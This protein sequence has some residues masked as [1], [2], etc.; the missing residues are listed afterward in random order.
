MK[1]NKAK[2]MFSTISPVYETSI[3]MKSIYKA[4]GSETELS[5]ELAADILKQLFPQTATWGLILWEERL[6]LI[7]NLNEN[8]Q[9]RRAKVISKLQSRNKIINP[10]QMALIISNY[11]KA[12]VNIVEDVAPYMF[13]INLLSY[14]GFPTELKDMYKEVKRIKPSHLGVNY[15]LTAITQ[16][17]FFIGLTSFTGEAITTYP[18][19]PTKIESKTNVFI[20]IAQHSGLENIT[21]Y[22]KG[23]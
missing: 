21:T 23:D 16:S 10:Y 22:P 18:W 13:E 1:S 20:P 15:K 14:E 17:K 7:T 5:E 2:E 12:K 19:T 8:I 3:V 4:I 11:T 9:L 6:K